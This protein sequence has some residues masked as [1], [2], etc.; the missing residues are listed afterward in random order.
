MGSGDVSL[1]FVTDDE[2]LSKWGSMYVGPMLESELG[3]FLS[4]YL[5]FNH[6]PLVPLL[7]SSIFPTACRT[8]QV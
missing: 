2:D 4:P 6:I 3:H 7:N 8:H 1:Y 5:D